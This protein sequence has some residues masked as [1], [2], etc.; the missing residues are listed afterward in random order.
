MSDN[1]RYFNEESARISKEQLD[2][3][4]KIAAKVDEAIR[5]VGKIFSEFLDEQYGSLD[6]EDNAPPPSGR[7]QDHYAMCKLTA[8][9]LM[10]RALLVFKESRRTAEIEEFSDHLRVMTSMLSEFGEDHLQEISRGVLSAL[11]KD[12]EK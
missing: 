4:R 11:E 10:S 8:M 2:S 3:S 9:F 6:P 12:S 1:I 5:Q 7:I